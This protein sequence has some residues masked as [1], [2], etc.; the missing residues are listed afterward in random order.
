LAGLALNQF[1]KIERFNNH[2]REIAAVYFREL[3]DIAVFKED[4]GKRKP[5]FMRFPLK[6]SGASLIISEARRFGLF[7]NDGW[8]ETIIVPPKTVQEKWD[9]KKEN[10]G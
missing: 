3:K 8:R 2:R 7:L 9:T 4:F 6:I 5:V 1:K 10:A